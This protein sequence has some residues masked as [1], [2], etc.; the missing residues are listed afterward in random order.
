MDGPMLYA[1]MLY[2]M[3]YSPIRRFTGH[4]NGCVYGA[5]KKFVNGQT[6]L[7]NLYL[8]GTDQ[9]FLGIVGAMLRGITIANRYLLK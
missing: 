9:G 1:T 3:L 6:S 8:C 2:A 5:P 4:L 7:P